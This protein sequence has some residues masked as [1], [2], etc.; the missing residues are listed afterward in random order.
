MGFE[1]Q[2]HPLRR[3]LSDELHARSINEFEGGEGLSIHIYERIN[4]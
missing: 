1:M 3:K 2:E 4:R